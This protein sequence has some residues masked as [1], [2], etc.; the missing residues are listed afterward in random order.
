M[1][2]EAATFTPGRRIDYD[3]IVHFFWSVSQMLY[4]STTIEIIFPRICLTESAFLWFRIN[5]LE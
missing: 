2:R 1:S 3:V 5:Q 4:L